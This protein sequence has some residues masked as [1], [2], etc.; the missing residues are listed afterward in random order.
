[1]AGGRGVYTAPSAG[2]GHYNYL[3]NVSAANVDGVV[4]VTQNKALTG[5]GSL[6][7]TVARRNDT[8][9]YQFNTRLNGNGRSRPT[10]EDRQRHRDHDLGQGDGRGWRLRHR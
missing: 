1:M 8:T 10:Y 5:S 2:T 9:R 3:N 7:A 4:D 6:F